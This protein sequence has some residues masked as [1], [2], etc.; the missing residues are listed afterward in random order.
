MDKIER[1]KIFCMVAEQ[2]SFAKVARILSLPRSTVTHAIKNLEKNYEVLLFYRTTRKVNLTHEGEL[3][4]QEATQLIHLLKELNRFK[5]QVKSTQGKI[6]IGLPKRMATQILIPH[7][8]NFY[9]QH[10]G[11]KIHI[12][13]TDLYSNLI[14]QQLDCVVRV[15][16]AHDEYLI[17]KTVG[18][19][20]LST[21][22]SPYYIEQYGQPESLESLS[23]HC[24]V[25]YLVEK[26]QN[27]Y[28]KLV[29]QN[30]QIALQHQVIVEDTESYIQAGL[31][32]MGIIQIPEF[33]AREFIKNGELIE[34]F[35][36]LIP[37]ELPIHL[38]SPDRKYRP[39]YLHDFMAWLAKLIQRS[40]STDSKKIDVV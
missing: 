20:H 11:I 13:C 3:F 30:E 22:V 1:L 25:D 28:T 40:L 31:A 17:A 14:E 38:L 6:T 5:Y 9:R 19:T 2:Q 15:G 26:N 10:S 37:V 12:K 34:V 27:K 24:A 8:N 21:L 35:K 33:D 39:P 7:L 18:Y 16:D 29:F 4:F 36:N 23:Q 32:G